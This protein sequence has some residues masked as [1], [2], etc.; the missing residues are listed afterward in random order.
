MTQVQLATTQMGIL[1]EEVYKDIYFLNDTNVRE[2]PII[3]TA[4]GDYIIIESIS[5]ATDMQALLL[6][7][8]DGKFVIAFRGTEGT[9]GDILSDL[10]NGFVNYNPQIADARDF[11]NEMLINHANIGLT[12]SNLTLTGHSLGGMLT[13]EIGS[14]MRIPGYAFNPYGME[15]L[16]S[17]PGILSAL[18]LLGPVGVLAQVLSYDILIKLGVSTPNALW[19]KDNII[20]VSYTDSG[21]LNGDVLSNLTTNLTSGHIGAFVPLIG[22]DQGLIDG[23]SIFKMNYAIAIYNEILSHFTAETTYKTLTDAYLVN[24]SMG[25]FFS[26][27]AFSPK[28]MYDTTNQYLFADANI[29]NNN[30]SALSFNLFNNL[31]NTQIADQAKIDASVLFALIRLNGFAVKGTLSSY[32]SLNRDNYSTLF[33]EDRSLLLYNMLDPKKHAIGDWFIRDQTYGI[34]ANDDG[35]HYDNNQILF[36]SYGDNLLDG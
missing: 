15:R 10:L 25:Y 4:Y 2:K 7:G 35:W 21:A 30:G 3:A 9:A 14:E 22:E 28:D 31:T 24:Q 33:I 23:H 34:T 11:V 8:P 6:Q 20:N 19:A 5:T 17:M 18:T 32:N 16:M 36:G 13:Q 29:Y 12:S 26:S 1:S 27:S